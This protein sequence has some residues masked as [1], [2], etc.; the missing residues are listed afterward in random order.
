MTGKKVQAKGKLNRQAGAV[1][2]LAGRLKGDRA[3]QAKG[4]AQR[5]KGSVQYA[6]GVA[7]RKVTE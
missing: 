6:A 7:S 2:Q 1:R 3:L 4:L 5:A